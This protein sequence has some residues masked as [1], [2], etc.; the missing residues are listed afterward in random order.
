MFNLFKGQSAKIEEVVAAPVIAE[1]K[2]YTDIRPQWRA[3]AADRKIT[4][5]DIAA[6]CLYKAM[7][8]D[9]VP[10]L[11]VTKLQK[12]FKAVSNPVKIEN[13]AAPFAARD[14]AMNAVKYSTLTGWLTAEE[15][16]KLMDAAK[17]TK[18]ALK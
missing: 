4:R 6:L 17:S 3:L 7:L 16:T 8:K 18:A 12:A 15:Q 14:A 2:A 10:A 13:G 9:Q 11:A 5:E 1:K